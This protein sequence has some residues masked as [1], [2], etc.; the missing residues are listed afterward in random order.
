MSI[1]PSTTGWLK[2]GSER[3]HHASTNYR[4]VDISSADDTFTNPTRS[5]YVGGAGVLIVRGLDGQNCTFT[6]AAAGYHP[7]AC[8]AVVRTGTTATNMVALF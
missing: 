8:V 7:L 3:T 2:K 5:I 4:A 6:A 1:A